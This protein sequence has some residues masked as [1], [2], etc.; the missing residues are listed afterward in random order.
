MFSLIKKLLLLSSIVVA[1]GVS[2]PSFA[3]NLVQLDLNGDKV[4]NGKDIF[5]LRSCINQLPSCNPQ[6]DFNNDG[7]INLID[8][9]LIVASYGSNVPTINLSISGENEVFIAENTSF[10]ALYNVVV[11]NESGTEYSVGFSSSSTC[12]SVS[13][14]NNAGALFPADVTNTGALIV[15]ETINAAAT[16]EQCELTKEVFI[17]E[18]GLSAFHSLIVNVVPSTGN[19][20][21]AVP[22]AQPSGI[23]PDTP[24]DVM[25]TLNIAGTSATPQTIQVRKVDSNDADLGLLADLKD[26]GQ[27]PDAIAGD[28]VF[29]G[30]NSVVGTTLGQIKYKVVA[31]FSVLGIF[32]SPSAI[33]TVTDLTI[34]L[35]NDEIAPSDI[36][37]DPILNETVVLGQILVQL[38]DGVT[39]EQASAAADSV[40]FS[41]LGFEPALNTML[42]A[43]PKTLALTDAMAY[44]EGAG[45]FS[46]VSANGVD[47][48]SEFVPNDPSYSSQWGFPKTRTDEAWVVTRGAGVLVGV[49]D[50]G[51]D[52]DHPDLAT[53]ISQGY[54]AIDGDTTPEA[55]DKHGTHVAG[56]IAALT[57]NSSQVSGM[58]PDAKLVIIRTLGPGGGS[59]A[60]FADGVKRAADLGVKIINYSGG[61]SNSTTKR[62]A[63]DYAVGKG[64]LFVAA[65]GNDSTS[66]TTSAFPAAYSNVMAIGSTTSTDARSSFS[67]FG[68][69]VTMAAPGSSILSLDLAGG[70]TTL[71]GTSMATPHVAGAAALVWSAHPTLT[72]AQVR[73]RLIKS[74]KPLSATLQLGAGRLDTF[75]AVFNGNFEMGAL[76]GWKKSGTAS[77]VT[78]LGP[79]SP[80]LGSRMAL[81][82][83]GPG[84]DG[85]ETELYQDFTV[86]SGVSSIPVQLTYNFVSEEYPEFVGTQFNDCVNVEIQAPNGSIYVVAAESI[87]NS[88]FTSIAGI[89]FPGGDT[90]S[91]QTGWKTVAVDV[92]VTAGP[93]KYRVFITDAGDDIYDSIMLLDDIR[94]KASVATGSPLSSTCN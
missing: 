14:S 53:N 13:A 51:A 90:T 71:N 76:E 25:F 80:P 42:I 17:T 81:T 18:L 64:V 57:N 4:I 15:N 75:N 6:A 1:L 79:L 5:M 28:Y 73:E 60:Q 78:L 36:V 44:L 93:G 77:S 37:V 27:S 43:Y 87:N 40:G 55:V 31:D 19:P 62:N 21:L 54:D 41:V 29:T 48:V 94:F 47:I 74:A 92:P 34:G 91:G 69:W 46:S 84:G 38:T 83:T 7:I 59:H 3:V 24:T 16:I 11:N 52:L 88:T 63:V 66:S 2:L 49:V 32:N 30:S 20:I 23:A 35:S 82:S 45:V 58:A 39:P 65:A 33:L 12:N 10:N 89:D 86:Q 68:S 56:T 9:K 61:G 22:G 67:N 8:Y 70:T 72:A 50:T 26:D 85:A